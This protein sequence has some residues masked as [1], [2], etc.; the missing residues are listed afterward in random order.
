MLAST[1]FLDFV[2][3]AKTSAKKAKGSK[4]KKK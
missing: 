3:A 1:S 2:Q 4:G